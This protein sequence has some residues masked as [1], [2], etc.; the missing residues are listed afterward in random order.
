META[1]YYRTR[2][3]RVLGDAIDCFP[4]KQFESLVIAVCDLEGDLQKLLHQKPHQKL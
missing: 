2:P 1:F 4:P 3:R